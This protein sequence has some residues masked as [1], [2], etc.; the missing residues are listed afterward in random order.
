MTDFGLPERTL[1]DIAAF[2]ARYPEIE[3]VKIFG[4]RATGHYR[5]GSDIDIALCGP[6]DD[7]LLSRIAGGLDNLSTPYK[8][9]IVVY[10]RISHPPL[11]DHIDRYGIDFRNAFD[12]GQQVT[13]KTS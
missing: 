3:A 8:Y 2:L 4:S 5:N 12:N 11:K 7:I 13:E 10:D 9:D 1:K 6:I